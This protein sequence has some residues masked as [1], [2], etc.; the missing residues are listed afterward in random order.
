MREAS[1]PLSAAWTTFAAEAVEVV[2]L[3]M[4]LAMLPCCL[5]EP[6]VYIV[7]IGTVPAPMAPAGGNGVTTL[8]EACGLELP[9]PWGKWS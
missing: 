9:R 2:V 4:K 7:T 1:Y 3:V 6:S 8:Y 5:K